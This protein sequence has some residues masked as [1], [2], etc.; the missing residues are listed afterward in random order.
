[1]TR[2]VLSFLLASASSAGAEPIAIAPGTGFEV[3]R[4]AVALRPDLATAAVSGTETI[5]LQSTSEGLAQLA[6]TANALRIND[7]TVDGAPVRAISNDD[8][9]IFTLPRTLEKGDKVALHFRFEG[10]PARGIT[11]VAGGLYTSYFACDWMVCLQDAPGDKAHLTL[12]LF[13]PAGATSIGVGTREPLAALA[14]DL[15]LHRW[16]STRPYSPYV[17][18]FAAGAFTSQ[19]LQTVNGELVYL[20]ATGDGADLTALFAQTP[21]IAAFL[22]DKAGMALPDSRYV[23]VLVPGREAQEAANFSLIGKAELDRERAD[24]SSAWIITH[25]MAHQWWGNLVTCATWQDFWLNEGIATFMVAA[26]K[27]HSLGPAAYRHELERAR[28]RLERAREIGFDKPLAWAGKYPSLGARRAV[29]YS[30]GALFLAHLR[31][32]IGDAAFW[33]GLR[34]FTRQ[35]AGSTV[36]GRDFQAAMEKA[37]G[38][39]LTRM[40]VEWVYGE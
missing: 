17:Y 22:A 19:S 26:W 23:Q 1:M 18:G 35:N 31:A 2:R 29:Q 13:L 27:E 3:E 14:D 5:V 25:E 20:D 38:R 37:S 9:I 24:P 8:A 15:V 7:A 10:K 34:H 40:F 36:T 32:T 12:D 4:Y 11:A 33:E 28:A 16:R 21:A 6:F 39:D 30:K